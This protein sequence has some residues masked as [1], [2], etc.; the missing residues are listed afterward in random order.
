MKAIAT[1]LLSAIVL[2]GCGDVSTQPPGDSSTGDGTGPDG[3]VPDA[4]E[5]PLPDGATTCEIEG[6]YCTT[7]ALVATPCVTCEPVGGV[8]HVPA[9]GPDG[10]N[11]CT[12]EG[13]GV[14]AWCCQP[15][16]MDALNDCE[17]AGGMCTPHGG[18][19]CPVGW[20]DD[21]AGTR[22]GGSHVCCVPGSACP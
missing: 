10:E 6:G 8:T 4:V 15:L 7:Y 17:S 5:E 18:E 12:A 2:A 21:P 9:R 16:D 3:T 19:R 20:E 13:D 14:G 1:T 22:C 11:E